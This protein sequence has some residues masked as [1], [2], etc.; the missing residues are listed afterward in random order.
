[1]KPHTFT[2]HHRPNPAKREALEAWLEEHKPKT[3][4]TQPAPEQARERQT[5]KKAV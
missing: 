5:G 1:M 4:T 2:I 3:K